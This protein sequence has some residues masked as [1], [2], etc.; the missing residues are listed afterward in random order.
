MDTSKLA[1]LGIGHELKSHY[2]D[3]I[4]ATNVTEGGTSI[5]SDEGRIRRVLPRVV[6]T[7][8]PDEYYTLPGFWEE[9]G[10][11]IL[12][13][14]TI[15]FRIHKKYIGTEAFPRLSN[16][17][18]YSLA[19]V[20]KLR[21]EMKELLPESE[22]EEN[23]FSHGMDDAIAHLFRLVYNRENGDAW[24]SIS[25]DQVNKLLSQFYMSYPVDGEEGMPTPSYLL[26]V[27][28]VCDMYARSFRQYSTK[29]GYGNTTN[30]PPP[31]DPQQT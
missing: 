16:S 8:L 30:Q 29:V 9:F 11:K 1:E 27:R 25:E 6:V 5:I 22:R 14:R 18:A 28:A 2:R 26:G 7:I 23:L 15:L 31:P 10:D 19:T 4:V 24:N 3:E 17:E 12:D 20:L 21:S 13:N